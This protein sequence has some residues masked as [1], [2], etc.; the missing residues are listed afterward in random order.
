MSDSCVCHGIA[1]PPL[2]ASLDDGFAGVVAMNEAETRA[3]YID[4]A[5][6]AAGWGVVEASRIRREYLKDGAPRG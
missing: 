3:D 4:P 6:K 5:L 2:P 1:T